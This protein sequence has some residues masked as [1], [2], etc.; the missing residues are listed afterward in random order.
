MMPLKQSFRSLI[1]KRI[2]LMLIEIRNPLLG[3]RQDGLS[4]VSLNKK[5]LSIKK[6]IKIQMMKSI[7]REFLMMDTIGCNLIRL[8]NYMRRLK[9]KVHKVDSIISSF[10]ILHFCRLSISI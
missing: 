10:L 3:Y 2:L 5:L 7:K 6:R 8:Y 4:L 9:D 1:K